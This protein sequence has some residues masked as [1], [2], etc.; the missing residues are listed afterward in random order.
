LEFRRHIDGMLPIGTALVSE[1]APR[2]IRTTV[3][4]IAVV[5]RSAAGRLGRP[6]C[7]A[8]HVDL[9][10]ARET[11]PPALPAP[12]AD[13]TARPAAPDFFFANCGARQY[14]DQFFMSPDSKPAL[15]A[16]PDPKKAEA[17][18]ERETTDAPCFQRVV[19]LFSLCYLLLEKLS[20]SLIPLSDC[21]FVLN[22]LPV[23]LEN[24][25]VSRKKQS[26]D[27][28]RPENESPRPVSDPIGRI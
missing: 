16:P 15:S 4:V 13:R 5:G 18:Q 17:G 19:S 3:I 8:I 27:R 7:R 26:L 21:P 24:L 23:F 12:R 14:G 25:P 11:N 20:K 6:R 9:W 28:H 22:R 2:L 10:R 1:F